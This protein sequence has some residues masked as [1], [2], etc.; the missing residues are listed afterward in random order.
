[1]LLLD[2]ERTKYLRLENLP[3]NL[4]K[5]KR[6]PEV[7]ARNCLWL[8]EAPVGIEPTNGGFAD[9]CLTTW[10]RRRMLRR[11]CYLARRQRSNMCRGSPLRSGFFG[12]PLMP[13]RVRSQE[14][15]VRSQ[16]SR[17]TNWRLATGNWQLATGDWPLCWEHG[18]TRRRNGAAHYPGVPASPRVCRAVPGHR[19][20]SLAAGHHRGSATVAVASG[21]G[22]S[23]ARRAVDGGGALRVSGRGPAGGAERTP[24]PRWRSLAVSAPGW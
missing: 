21:K 12:R 13:I 2:C 5:W 22:D 4:P 1:M 14:S 6:A 19:A 15:G 20:R 7:G 24:H 9:L 10:L 23:A 11:G 3:K 8:K 16:E 18:R 17:V